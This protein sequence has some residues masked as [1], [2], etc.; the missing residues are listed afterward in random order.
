MAGIK[1]AARSVPL[2]GSRVMATTFLTVGSA[3]WLVLL[4]L[5]PACQ[6]SVVFLCGT[7]IFLATNSVV[8][9]IVLFQKKRLLFTVNVL[10]V[11]LFAM[12]FCQVHRVMG[13]HHFRVVEGPM[14]TDWH[15]FAWSH[16]LHAADLL[17]FL[18]GY[19]LRYNLIEH[20]SFLAGAL[21]V[22]MH[23]HVSVYI[24]GLIVR[25]VMRGLPRGTIDPVQRR[26]WKTRLLAT[27][28]YGSLTVALLVVLTAHF[29]RWPFAD[30]L[31]WPL[32]QTL[33]TVDVGGIFKIS[34]YHLHNVDQSF[35]C[36]LLGLLFRIVVGFVVVRSLHACHL[37]W[38]GGRALRPLED[39]VDDLHHPHEKVREAA[40]LAL[41]E[42]GIDA[43]AAVPTLI[44]TIDDDSA[45]VATATRRAL[46]RVCPSHPFAVPDLAEQLRHPNWAIR[47]A[48]V[49]ALGK[50]GPAALG[51]VPFL[52]AKLADDDPTI[53]NLAE[54][55]LQS[56][57]PG[58]ERG[59]LA[60]NAVPV[61]IERL[62]HRKPAIRQSA[63][64]VLRRLGPGARRAVPALLRA[65]GD[66]E[67]YPRLSAEWALDAIQPSW[68]HFKGRRL[69]LYV[70]AGALE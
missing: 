36:N 28:H 55:A 59:S 65:L 66:D 9:W 3:V 37:R 48:A 60:L 35:W 70:E 52:V 50:M 25:R 17:H 27:F 8:S 39:F 51:A 47:R 22:V 68:R 32:E 45:S 24:I 5:L 13:P 61:L 10:Q 46:E 30:C 6:A 40:A 26:L 41:R 43:A 11:L 18:G 34:G 19:G 69:P 4:T 29:S 67:E 15:L 31:L 21:L 16:A 53:A 2:F 42:I 44:L 12:L 14:L 54:Q 62:N 57:Y 64:D 49:E 56:I 33:R 1:P 23:L 20:R 7:I 63:A 38:L 58:W